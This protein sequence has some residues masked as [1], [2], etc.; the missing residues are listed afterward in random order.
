MLELFNKRLIIQLA[1]FFML[2]AGIAVA[3]KPMEIPV[4]PVPLE[5]QTQQGTISY[6][7]EIAFAPSQAKAGLMYRTH[8]PRD[9][10]MLFKHQE[11]D[12]L[13]DKQGLIMWMANTPLPLDMLFLNDEGV[14]VSIVEKTIPFSTDMISSK[15]PAA[16]VIEVNAGEVSE[17]QIEKGQRVFH[18][19]ICGECK[20]SNK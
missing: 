10:A 14:I 15:V 2:G 1:L 12:K 8:F 18:P 4:D 17:K 3:K 11:N 13:G 19:A 9:H 7:V 20:G 5:I 16:F 6:K